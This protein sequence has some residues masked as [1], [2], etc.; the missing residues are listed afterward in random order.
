MIWILEAY[1]VPP[2]LLRAINLMNSKTRAKVISPDSDTDWF[3]H[4]RCPT[5]WHLGTL[6]VYFSRKRFIISLRAKRVNRA[7]SSRCANLTGSYIFVWVYISVISG[8]CPHPVWRHPVY[9]ALLCFIHVM[10]V[11]FVCETRLTNK[12]LEC[13]WHTKANTTTSGCKSSPGPGRTPL[14]QQQNAN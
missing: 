4:H 7:W 6:S 10:H 1:G 2:L 5:T 9:G 12:F 11:F 8:W 14:E 3:C 13:K